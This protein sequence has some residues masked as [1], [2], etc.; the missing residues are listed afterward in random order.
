VIDDEA[1][2]AD[3]LV[4]A[5]AILDD[6]ARHAAMSAAAHSLARPAAADAIAELM[7]ALAARRSLPSPDAVA[8]IAAGGSR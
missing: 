1:F 3:T 2:D 8:A 4:G 7:L 5:L 6:P